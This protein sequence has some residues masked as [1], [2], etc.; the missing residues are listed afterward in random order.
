MGSLVVTGLLFLDA[1]KIDLDGRG[2]L[3]QS[4]GLLYSRQKVKINK[5]IDT[6]KNAYD[7]AVVRFDL[8]LTD[9]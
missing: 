1:P 5:I 6:N 9:K 8:F 2:L 3:D 4:V 7:I